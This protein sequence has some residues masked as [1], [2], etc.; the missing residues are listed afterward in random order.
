MISL[1]TKSSRTF[2]SKR[3]VILKNYNSFILKFKKTDELIYQIFDQIGQTE[4]DFIVYCF[5]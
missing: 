4:R 5:L 3:I 2:K 1:A